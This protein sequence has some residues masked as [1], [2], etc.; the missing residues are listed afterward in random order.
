VLY[1]DLNSSQAEVI[2]KKKIQNQT[3]RSEGE[4]A[5]VARALGLAPQLPTGAPRRRE[6]FNVAF[7]VPRDGA[8]TASLGKLGQGFTTL[9][10][11]NFFFISSL[12]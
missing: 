6:T 11:E 4:H 5:G 8:P 3:E 2:T 12:I 1:R 9:I 10:V 7:S